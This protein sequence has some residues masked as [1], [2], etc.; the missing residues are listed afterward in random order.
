MKTEEQ[1]KKAMAE[2]LP[3]RIRIRG[4]DE[5][6]L[7]WNEGRQSRF[8]VDDTELLSICRE[9]ELGLGYAEIIAYMGQ[10]SQPGRF[11]FQFVTLSWQQRAEA[12]AAVKGITI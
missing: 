11:A 10:L 3:E 8:A 12:L 4:R 2:M 1:L 9:I 7:T 6:I 5:K